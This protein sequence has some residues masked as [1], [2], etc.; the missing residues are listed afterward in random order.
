MDRLAERETPT[1]YSWFIRA[2]CYD[3]LWQKVEAVAA[4]EKFLTLDAGRSQTQG[5]QARARIRTLKRE[6]EQKR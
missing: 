4:Y 3:K 2:T 1:A 5:I 6:L